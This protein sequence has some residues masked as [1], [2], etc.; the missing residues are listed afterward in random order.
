MK[1][2]IAYI[3]PEKLNEIKKVL[4]DKEIKRFSVSDSF[5]HSDAPGIL[6]SYRGVE[7]SID[8]LKKIRVEIAVND[9]FKDILVG[10]LIEAGKAGLI[11][12]GKIFVLPLEESYRISTGAQ[13]P[14][15]IN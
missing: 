11:G 6:E 5:G 9:D 4:Y 10:S 8:L 13:G 1:L 12:D 2:V 14:E 15:G 3:E 7:M